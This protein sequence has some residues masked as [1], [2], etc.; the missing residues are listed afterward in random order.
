M[1]QFYPDTYYMTVYEDF[2]RLDGSQSY[3]SNLMFNPS[4]WRIGQSYQIRTKSALKERV[5]EK[6]SHVINLSDYTMTETK[7]GW[8]YERFMRSC[9]EDPDVYESAEEGAHTDH[10][11]FTIEIS[12]YE[13]V[14]GILDRLQRNE[15]LYQNE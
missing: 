7:Y 11:V 14:I 13:E 4:T 10:E 2:K 15:V 1:D 12:C 9:D 5:E 3:Y 8:T 6:M